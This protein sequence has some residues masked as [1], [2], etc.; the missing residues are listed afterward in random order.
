MKEGQLCFAER[1]ARRQALVEALIK[2]D[3]HLGRGFITDFP[4]STDHIVRA[5][6][7]EGPSEPNRPFAGEGSCAAS[8]T[9]GDRNEICADR[10]LDDIARVK[11]E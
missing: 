1:C 5:G 6:T 4:E 3:H 8:I 2:I 11:L 7:K 9:R 10:M